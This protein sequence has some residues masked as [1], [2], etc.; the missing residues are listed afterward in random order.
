M[1]WLVPFTS[2]TSGLEGNGIKPHEGTP[3]PMC[4]FRSGLSLNPLA[5]YLAPTRG[6]VGRRA[7][8]SQATNFLLNFDHLSQSDP[9]SGDLRRRNDADFSSPNLAATDS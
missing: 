7:L 2:V 3:A 5:R 9:I 1:L 6:W 4:A 8:S